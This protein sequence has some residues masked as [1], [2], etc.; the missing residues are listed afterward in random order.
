MRYAILSAIFAVFLVPLYAFADTTA[1]EDTDQPQ[2]LYVLSST[3]GTATD[4]VLTLQGVPT[5]VYIADNPEKSVGYL[6]LAEFIQMW[7]K[8][9]SFRSD[10]PNATLSILD[11]HGLKNIVIEISGARL[12]DTSVVLQY[13]VL[14][15]ELPPSFDQSSLFVDFDV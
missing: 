5:V 14:Y 8:S 12:K 13:R 7:N 1:T 10:P 2:Y 11:E 6:K 9:D 15:G 4:G 3:S